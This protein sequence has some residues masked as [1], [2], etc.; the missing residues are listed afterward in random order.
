MDDAGNPGIGG[1][2]PYRNTNII[3]LK[4]EF[5]NA[6]YD[7]RHRVTVNGMYELPFGKERKYMHEGGV[8]D[9]LVGGWST[10]LTWVAQ[11]G[12]PFT[13]KTGGGNFVGANG[14][15]QMNAIKV[16]DPF[17]GGSGSFDSTKNLDT[18]SC[19]AQVKTRAHWFNPC[20][21]IDPKSGLSANIPTGTILTDLASALAY[22]GSKS[23][24][25]HGPGYERINMSL[26]KNFK[27]WREQYFQFRV[28][29]FNLFNH[30]SWSLPENKTSTDLG[31]TDNVITSTQSF[32][33]L[34]PD[35]RFLQ[36][37]GKYVF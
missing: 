24:Q 5:T 30:P 32:Q 3:P 18:T 33:N 20:A 4:A 10:S 11:T 29:A 31:S 1:G 2:P 23:N 16:G 27:T 14:F 13:V 34:T 17:K 7:T 21:F 37:A 9:Y 15:G 26:F 35:S 28:D 12:V 25:I 8:L 6:N 22:S 36:I 19:P